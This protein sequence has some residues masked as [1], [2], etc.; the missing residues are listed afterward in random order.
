MSA[1]GFPMGPSSSTPHRGRRQGEQGVT[2]ED[3]QQP[4]RVRVSSV[5]RRE[6]QAQFGQWV[7]VT[8]PGAG[9][10]RAT[11]EGQGGSAAVWVRSP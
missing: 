11:W 3:R 10:G 9:V 8:L 6:A 7:H 5:G 1:M 2:M 4:A